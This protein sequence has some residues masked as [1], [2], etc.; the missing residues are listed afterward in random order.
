MAG[1]DLVR[2]GTNTGGITFAAE[3]FA[4]GQRI[5]VNTDSTST[6]VIQT[7]IDQLSV[8]PGSIAD[9]LA[10]LFGPTPATSFGYDPSA[11]WIVGIS[12][13][14]SV[15]TFDILLVDGEFYGLV[16]KVGKKPPPRTGTARTGT[17]RTGTARTATTLRSRSPASRSR[18][19]TARSTTTWASSRPT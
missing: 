16:I 3:E 11:D 9:I 4:F 1:T 8:V 18:S 15:L 12:L 2:L 14:Y 7:V 17:A 13:T 10:T 6:S 19:S 5:G